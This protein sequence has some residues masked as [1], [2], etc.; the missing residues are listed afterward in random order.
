MMFSS[1]RSYCQVRSLRETC[2]MTDRHP[3]YHRQDPSLPRW[4]LPHQHSSASISLERFET[5][6]ANKR[7]FN[8]F[9]FY[10]FLINDRFNYMYVFWGHLHMCMVSKYSKLY[11]QRT[12]Q[13]TVQQK[14]ANYV[15]LFAQLIIGTSQVKPC[16]IFLRRPSQDKT[17]ITFVT[18]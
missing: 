4:L 14:S 6:P 3:S 11:F 5:K 13:S 9:Q 12:V 16:Y 18:T 2:L 1:M 7:K 8:L 17:K 15:A 10:Q